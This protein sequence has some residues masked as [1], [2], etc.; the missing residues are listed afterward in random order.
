MLN[1]CYMKE[2]GR[3]GALLA[4]SG[5][6]AAIGFLHVDKLGRHSLVWDAVEPLRPLV[7]AKVFVFVKEH[8]GEIFSG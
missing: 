4:A 8:R 7:E 3:L 6:C 2:A 1:N 5:A